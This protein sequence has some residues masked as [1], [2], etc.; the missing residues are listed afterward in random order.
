MKANPCELGEGDDAPHRLSKPTVPQRIRPPGWHARDIM[1]RA[2]M[3]S[4]TIGRPS[5]Y[6]VFRHG[7]LLFT[8]PFSDCPSSGCQPNR[9]GMDAFNALAP[10][11]RWIPPKK[12]WLATSSE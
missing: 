11:L 6:H 1:G 5:T 8:K 9:I 10:L 3:G 4:I 12:G 2:N 7:L